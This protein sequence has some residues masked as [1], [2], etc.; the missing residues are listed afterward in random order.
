ME[1]SLALPFVVSQQEQ[2]SIRMS[3]ITEFTEEIYSS[4]KQSPIVQ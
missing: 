2:L 3:G 4:A 1:L